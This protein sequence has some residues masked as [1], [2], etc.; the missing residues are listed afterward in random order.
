VADTGIPDVAIT[1]PEASANDGTVSDGAWPPVDSQTIPAQPPWPEWAFQHW[2]WESEST[3][4]SATALV[5]D[6]LAHGIPVGAVI[7]DSPW[8]A[9]Y[10]TFQWHPTLF[11]NPTQ[12][13]AEMHQKNVRVML[14][15]V[16]AIN[17]DVKSLY[18]QAKD[19]KYF[20]QQVPFGN[21]AVIDWWHQLLDQSLAYG[22]D[23]WK[24]DGLDFSARLLAQG[25]NN[26]RDPH[27]GAA[28]GKSRFHPSAT[29]GAWRCR[30]AA[31]LA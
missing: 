30:P 26:S 18:P 27:C 21:P 29:S 23:G 8:E 12:M 9:G 16:P 17:T 10:N 4:Q 6:Y 28:E 3:Q 5:N 13:I 20:M 15:I 14:W 19:K 25:N 1:N 31:T 11:P 2:V 24:C 22:I 7:S